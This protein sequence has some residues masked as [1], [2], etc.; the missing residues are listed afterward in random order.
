VRAIAA[1]LVERYPR[2]DGVGEVAAVIGH[3]H[4]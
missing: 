2:A 1:E 4:T 3:R